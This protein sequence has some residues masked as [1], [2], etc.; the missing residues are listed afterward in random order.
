MREI[1]VSSI[2]LARENGLPLSSLRNLSFYPLPLARL[3]ITDYELRQVSGIRYTVF[4]RS[5]ERLGFQTL[6]S[7]H[8]L[9][10]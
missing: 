5:A 10:L 3:T 2:L 8:C 6:R 1:C 4:L 9:R 7:K